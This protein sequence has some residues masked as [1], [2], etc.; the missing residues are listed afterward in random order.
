MPSI[1]SQDEPVKH[2]RVPRKREP[3]SPPRRYKNIAPFERQVRD[4]YT[5]EH[6]EVPRIRRASLPTP[7]PELDDDL[8]ETDNHRTIKRQLQETTKTT[9][10]VRPAP[11][12]STAKRPATTRRPSATRHEPVSFTE[13]RLRSVSTRQ[14]R[15]ILPEEKQPVLP[16]PLLQ[17]LAK[18]RNLAIVS[19]TL[20]ILLIFMYV[21]N[22][23]NT[24][25]SQVGV[26]PGKPPGENATQPAAVEPANPHQ[27]VILPPSTSHPAPPVLAQAAFL[28]DAD[29]GAVLYAQNP[30]MHL[31]VLSTTKLMTAMLAAELGDPDQRVTI[32]DAMA[33]DINRLSTDSSLMHIKKGETY[34][35]KDLLYGLLLVSGN[36][37]AVVIAHHIGGDLKKFVEKMNQQAAE[38]GLHDTH[39]MNPHGLL[40]TGHYSS[41]RDLVML[42][43]V[44]LSIPLVHEISNTREFNIPE[45]KDHP[46]HDMA[47][48]NQFLWW[49]PGADGGK[50]G[51]DAASNFV[52]VISCVRD[53]RHLIAAVVYTSDWWTDMRN[54]MNWGFDDYTWVSPRE[55]TKP[56]PFSAAWNYFERD[57]KENTIPIG[58]QGRYYIYTGFS[59]L[60]PIVDFFDKNKGLNTFGYPTE[61]AKPISDTRLTQRFEKATIECEQKDKK[62]QCKKV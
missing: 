29:S 34:T 50:P 57:K 20:V 44:S 36:D 37:A 2:T 4:F 17:K 53:G 30:F 3:Y 35:L 9:R 47:N 38:L 51:W 62:W 46:A 25:P 31:P 16:H 21:L 49:Y 12:R 15:Y 48:G 19:T 39:F 52:Q 22:Q 10:A 28:M 45:N 59:V 55:S 40:D 7:E 23:A 24:T 60:R 5:D 43:K 42:G 27:L 1:S 41:V 11:T 14:R 58:D 18:N 8:P 61:Q 56:V 13:P 33:K 54:L 26:L 6:P 32:N